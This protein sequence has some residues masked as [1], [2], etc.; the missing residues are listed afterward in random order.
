M[1]IIL[2]TDVDQVGK[3]GDVLDVSDGHARNYLIPKGLAMRASAGASA[4]ADEMR[5]ARDQ[6]DERDRDAAQEVATALVPKTIH[7]VAKAH[8]GGKLFG[9]VT[10]SDIA[11]AVKDQTTIVLDPDWITINEAIKVVGTHYVMAK[12][13][14]AVQ[15][16]ITVDIDTI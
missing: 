9:S 3:R 4:Q 15:F 10:A 12:L 13:H 5:R 1:K 6:R 7:I 16:P 2:R 11:A 8:E 14:Q